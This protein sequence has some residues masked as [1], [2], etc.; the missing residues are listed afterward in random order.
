MCLK[1]LESNPS[2]TVGGV[3]L[4]RIRSSRG[5][6]VA[7]VSQRERERES[8]LFLCIAR[9]FPCPFIFKIWAQKPTLEV[10]D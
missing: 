2:S 6:S 4:E 5:C 10:E 9:R 1:F 3:L 7:F 8:E